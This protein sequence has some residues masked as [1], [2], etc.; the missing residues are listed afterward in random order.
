MAKLNVGIAG[1]A[2]ASRSSRSAEILGRLRRAAGIRWVLAWRNLVQDQ[3]RFAATLIGIAFSVLLMSVEWGLLIGCANTAAGLIDHA[4]ADF[5]IVSRGTP[6]VDQGLPLPER[7]R[8]R[9]LAIP[10]I[11]AVDPL[12]THFVDW[13]RPD[14]GSEIVIIVGFDL[15]SGIGGPWHIVEGSVADLH[16]PDAIMLDRIYSKKLGVSGLGQTVE[17][18]G[19]R[20]RV[21]GF[22][23]GIR[24]FTQSPYVFTSVKNARKYANLKEN[25]AIDLL[26]RAEP[27]VDRSD[28]LAR[29]RTALPITDVWSARTF[30]SM[31]ASYWLLTTGAGLA[32]LVGAGLGVIV[33]IAIVAQTLYAATVERLSEYAT[34]VAIGAPNRYLNR[35]VLR[36][37]LSSGLIG[38][39]IGIGIACAVTQAAA[40]STASL[41]LPWELA[42]VVA[43]VTLAMCAIAS[44]LAIHKIKHIDPTLVF[45]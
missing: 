18:G 38:Y 14:G 4:G 36:Q 20:A 15:N 2:I 35:I 1:A 42:I 43:V 13:R 45:R 6:D 37:A 30:A 33:G 19:I 24:A 39:I 10:G 17:I 8:F 40:N 9:A 7:W 25:E 21:V 22:T 32:L 27:G 11:S 44:L 28:L 29:L 31:T 16:T 26:V 5:W 34:L 3:I 23:E 12:I 41:I